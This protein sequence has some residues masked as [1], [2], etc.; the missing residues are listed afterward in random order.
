MSLVQT[1]DQKFYPGCQKN[2]DDQIFRQRVLAVIDPKMRLLDLGAGAGI[3][4]AMN[5][6]G[7]TAQVCGVDLD[8]RVIQ[9]PFL[10][11]GKVSD[12]G[13]IPYPDASFD[14]VISD[15]VMEHLDRPEEVFRE[16]CRVLRPGGKLMFKTPNRT[17]YM[18]LIASMTPHS[19]HQWVNRRRGRHETDTFPTRY[20]CNSPAQIRL[21]AANVGLKLEQI[22]LIEGRP[23]YLRISAPTYLV[24]LVYERLVNA[25]P[26]FARFRILIIATLFKPEALDV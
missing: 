21:H 14:V 13:E 6:K 20:R 12:A 7:L 2:W 3:V 10:D 26:F 1:I 4:S 16:I 22:E 24:G 25:V 8:E 11:E 5:F 9:N 18:P 19:F 17:H 23:E 15:N